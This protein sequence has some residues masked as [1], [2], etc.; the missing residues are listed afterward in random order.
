MT[1]AS[2]DPRPLSRTC[3]TCGALFQPTHDPDRTCER[4]QPPDR[5]L[6]TVG[7]ALGADLV[8]QLLEAVKP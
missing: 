7:D 6:R 1:T 5:R 8:A 2:T 4:C 3:S